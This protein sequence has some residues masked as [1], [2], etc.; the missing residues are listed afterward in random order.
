[1]QGTEMSNI[2]RQYRATE[3][4]P[5]IVMSWP[6]QLFILWGFLSLSVWLSNA[7]P[8]YAQQLIWARQAGGGEFSSIGIGIAVDGSSNSYVTGSF[9]GTATFGAGESNETTLTSTGSGDLFVAKYDSDGLLIWAKQAGGTGGDRGWGIAVDG[10]GNSYVT[11]DFSLT[12]TFG[13]G[14]VNETTLTSAGG[15]DIF[16]AKYDSNGSL[17]WA[18]RDGGANSDIGR[19]IAVDENSNAYMTGFKDGNILLV[20]KHTSSGQLVW[21][22]QVENGQGYSIAV[23][24]SGNSYVTGDFGGTATFG[25]GEINETTL[26]SAGDS[27]FF[28]ADIFVAKYDSSGSLAWAKRAGGTGGDESGRGIAIDESGNSYVTGYFGRFSIMATFGAGEA[29]QTI[30]TSSGSDDI[31]VAKYDGG[32]SLLWA[33]RAGGTGGDNGLGIA[34]D[35]SSNSYV[36]GSFIGAATFGVGETNETELISSAGNVQIFVAKYD[37]S[38]GLVWARQAGGTN[39]DDGFSI[40]VD[41]S[42]SNYITGAFNAPA[43]IFGEGE[44]N[45]T[46]LTSAGR[47]IFVAK[48]GVICGDGILSGGETCDLGAT[49]GTAGACCT[50]SCT[51]VPADTTCR[52][53]AGACDIAESCT[54]T[55]AEC[56]SDTK[57]TAVCRPSAGVCDVT[58]S[59]DGVNNACP[60]DAFASA[61]TVCRP[62]ADQCDA[63]ESCTGSSASCSAHGSQPNGT[64]C[65]DSNPATSG[66]VCTNG[67][68]A[69][70]ATPLAVLAPNGG[71]SWPAGSTQTLRWNPSGV[72]GKVKLELSRDNG[73]TWTLLVNNTPNDGVQ[74]WTVTGPATEQALL[75]VSSMKTPGIADISNAMFTISGGGVTVLSP[76]GGEGWPI[77]SKRTIQWSSSNLNGKVKIELSRDGGTSWEVLSKNEANT[78][79]LTWKVKKP[80]TTQ[81]RIRVSGVD[82]PGAVDTS[83]ANFTIQ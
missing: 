45:E 9:G 27:D 35:G 8:G 83:N 61:A 68:C 57:S 13:A 58:E 49:N 21:A 29:N 72:S 19:G 5:Q 23:D 74:P 1:M 20:A 48:F 44:I 50:A 80:A 6:R 31:F 32:G 62:S 56:P 66:D 60:S 2:T 43:A 14:E 79:S 63:A 42:G 76:N 77:G 18:K 7:S 71:E 41:G 73:A 30:L 24:E 25:A 39:T 26:I 10:S 78:G 81:A 52:P 54:G 11:G 70:D 38:G 47:D 3:R 16:V 46:I 28:L 37:S 67:V 17:V 64:T 69:G 59:C 65:N 51:L 40:R 33:K 53:S 4:K 34:V 82:D 75:R 15:I 55:N 22:Q 12:A 36:T